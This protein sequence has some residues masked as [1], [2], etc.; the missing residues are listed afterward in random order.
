MTKFCPN[1]KKGNLDSAEYCENCGEQFK[2]SATGSPVGNQKGG[3]WGKQ[4]SGAKA[5][6]LIAGI[7][8]IGLIL[9]IGIG[10]MLS[11]DKSTSN[12]TATTT[13]TS[14]STSTTNTPTEVTI[15]QLY[16]GSVAKGTTVK[17]T[18]KVLQTDGSRLRMENTEG[19]DILVEGYNLNAYE[20]QSVTVIGTFYGPSTY[21]TAMGSSRTV[22]TVT[23]AKIA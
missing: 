17:V 19:Q 23:D 12:T 11:P 5:A 13:S 20:D 22:P 21:S 7:C 18:G 4:S 10:G 6:I 9:M 8:C 1:C 3:W 15:S 2:I 16:S 14:T